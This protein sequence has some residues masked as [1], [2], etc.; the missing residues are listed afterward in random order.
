VRVRAWS[1]AAGIGCL[2][3]EDDGP[4]IAPADLPHVFD[5]L[6]RSPSRTSTRQVGTG[7]GLAIVAELV[8]A[9]G[10]QVRADPAQGGGTR[11][12]VTLGPAA[13]RGPADREEPAR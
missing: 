6:W 12:T 2:E 7:L 5:P 11:V 4:G 9:M 13:R 3:V 8:A 10:G 1:P